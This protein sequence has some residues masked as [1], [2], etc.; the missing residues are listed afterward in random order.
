MKTYH[1]EIWILFLLTAMVPL[2]ANVS[3][4]K[5][6]GDIKVRMGLD[7]NWQ[8]AAPDMTLRNIDTILTGERSTV[9][10]N[11]SDEMTFTLGSQ[12]ILD[13]ADLRKITER[14]LFLFLTAEKV[15]QIPN[16]GSSKIRIEN[17]SVVRAD[18]RSVHNQ[19][20]DRESDNNWRYA[21]NGARALHQQNL[22]PNAVI[23]L[24]NILKKY[25]AV[26]D[27][28][29]IQLY[30]GQSFEA[31]EKNGRA[32]DAYHRAAKQSEKLNDA[33]IQKIHQSAESGI[34]RLKQNK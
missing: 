16:P 22:F 23:K 29:L 9:T 34:K 28:G 33:Q 4:L 21:V 6:Q 14:E 1:M 19:S 7:E 13:I 31:L 11:L 17:V 12:S 32:L 20:P 8:P 18:N 27:H 15:K 10:L 24:M 26:D 30:L 25:G 2:F 3:I 5:M